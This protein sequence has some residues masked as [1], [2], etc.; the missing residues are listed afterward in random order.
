MSA[1]AGRRIA[2]A[3]LA[4]LGI[5]CAAVAD[6]QSWPNHP[7]RMIVPFA[8]GG[9]TDIIARLVG[10]KLGERLGQSIVIENKPGAGTTVGNAEVAKARND[11]YTLLFAPTPFVISQVVYPSLPYDPQK[12][13]APVS[14]LAVSPFILVV[15]ASFPARTTAELVALAKAKPGTISFASAGNGTVPHLAGE[16]FKLRAGIDLQHVPYKGGGPAI[17][18]LVS[19]QVPMMFATPI[20]VSQHVQSGRLRVLGT[21]SLQR[22]ASLP[23]VPT[24][25]ESGY[26]DFEVLSF[27]GVLA[28]AGTP[29]DIVGRLATE[30]AAVMELADVRERFAQQSAEARVLGPAAFGTFLGREREK[31]TDIVKRSGAKVD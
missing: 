1:H 9:A 30:L 11:G 16:L 28:P 2:L 12:D 4:T 21:T 15:N 24:L 27:F 14:L 18:D 10:Q 29:A 23:D 26:P 8:P 5:A 31:W 13:F 25:S 3:L 22:L 6:A 17:I 19:G 20:E 7:V